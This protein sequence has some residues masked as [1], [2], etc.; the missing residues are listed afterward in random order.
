MNRVLQHTLKKNQYYPTPENLAKNLLESLETEFFDMEEIN[1]LEPCAGDGAICREV[2]RFFDILR[3]K[4]NIHCVEIE[5]VLQRSLK[6][7]GFYLIGSDFEQFETIPFYDLIFMNPPFSKGAKFI[8]KAYDLL[9]AEGRLICI[10][11]AQTIK[12][13]CNKERELLKNLIDRVGDVKYLTN[14]FSY[15]DRKTDIEI[16][17]VYLKKPLYENEFDFFGGIKN[18]ILTEEEKIIGELKDKVNNSQLVSFDKV[19]Y[20]IN[21][22]RSCVQ[23]IFKGIDTI[24]SIKNSLKY[25]EAEAREFNIE[26]EE[27]FKIMYEKDQE[28]AKGNV[29]KTIRKM[30]WSFVLKFCKMDQYLFH[31]QQDEFY[32]KIE[33]GSVSLPF[34]KGNILQFFDNIFLQR[35]KYFQAGIEDL[36]DEITSYHNGNKV[37]REGW[38]TNKNW[39]INKKIIVDW[40]VRFEDYSRYGSRYGNFR[41]G[42][43]DQWI[44]DLDKIVRKIKP[45]SASGFFIKEALRTRFLELG[46]VYI[47]NRK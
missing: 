43:N 41:A 6:G 2:K 20:S 14:A 31:K 17:V 25:L 10:L 3:K 40:G 4:I 47:Y 12:N 46:K 32:R 16:A 36:F 34:T 27:F 33:K 22:Y 30:V 45:D 1:F 11:N 35:A 23:Q 39:K 37:H 28:D 29:I 24:N 44:D 26:P 5:D 15:A 13:Q 18:D 8:L 21:V 38:K 42:R 7:Q 19:D 9:N